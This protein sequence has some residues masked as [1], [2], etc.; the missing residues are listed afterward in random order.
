MAKKLRPRRSRDTNPRGYNARLG[1]PAPPPPTSII[2]DLANAEPHKCYRLY[3]PAGTAG[4]QG[5]GVPGLTGDPTNVIDGIG[6]DGV[7]L[8][9]PNDPSTYNLRPGIPNTY[10][11][12]GDYLSEGTPG[13]ILEEVPNAR[14]VSIGTCAY[15]GFPDYNL[16]GTGSG[17]SGHVVGFAC[18]TVDGN[19]PVVGQKIACSEFNTSDWTY[20]EQKY[21]TPGAQSWWSFSSFPMNFMVDYSPFH[22]Q[23]SPYNRLLN[24][25]LSIGSGTTQILA[26]STFDTAIPP[27]MNPMGNDP[28]PMYA[29]AGRFCSGYHYGVDAWLYNPNTMQHEPAIHTNVQIEINQVFN[30][31]ADVASAFSGTTPIASF[32]G[33]FGEVPNSLSGLPYFCLIEDINGCTDPTA[34]NY[35]CACGSPNFTLSPTGIYTSADFINC[36]DFV[37][38]GAVC[39]SGDDPCILPIYGCTDSNYLDYNPNAN[40]DDGSCSSLIVLGCTD[41]CATNYNAAANTDDGSCIYPTGCMDPLAYNYDACAISD[42]GSCIRFLCHTVEGQPQSDTQCHDFGINGGGVG[43][44]PYWETSYNSQISK[45]AGTANV[46][47]TQEGCDCNCCSP[48]QTQSSEFWCPDLCSVPDH[49]NYSPLGNFDCN[50]DCIHDYVGSTHPTAASGPVTYTYTPNTIIPFDHCC[51]NWTDPPRGYTCGGVGPCEMRSNASTGD[52]FYTYLEPVRSWYSTYNYEY[53][54]SGALYP[55][56]SDFDTSAGPFDSVSNPTGYIIPA[57]QE[58]VTYFTSAASSVENFTNA[59]Y[60]CTLNAES[61]GLGDNDRSNYDPHCPTAL[62]CSDPVFTNQADCVSP[63]VWVDTSAWDINGVRSGEFKGFDENL[64]QSFYANVFLPPPY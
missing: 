57:G 38:T 5:D 26:G 24:H 43:S 4:G 35:N 46:W 23:Y 52:T 28:T 13:A 56:I 53:N 22:A 20:H 25:S 29:P 58:G 31:A 18:L 39:D 55:W 9:N 14:F 27:N 47:P 62:G 40:I 8:N 6:A 12:D 1:A 19:V 36:N 64:S 7:P 60:G 42:D 61:L 33:D 2:D 21:Y 17:T 11:R 54:L 16:W 37:T 51:V 3:N 34:F 49:S 50:R 44:N 15:P 45:P 41:T 48:N 10:W 59:I 30:S 63:D 32:D